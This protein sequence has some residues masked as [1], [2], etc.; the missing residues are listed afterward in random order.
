MKNLKISAT[1]EK[2]VYDAIHDLAV[3]KGM[4]MSTVIR[5]M[6]KEA[7]ELNKDIVLSKF[8]EER[9]KSFDKSKTLAHD[10]VWG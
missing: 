6:I 3:N 7:L 1:V 5:D 8:A 2:P 10:Q 9:E 4:A